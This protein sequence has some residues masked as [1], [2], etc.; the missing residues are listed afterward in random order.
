MKLIS[1]LLAAGTCFLPMMA[2]GT[3]TAQARIWCLSL[4]FQHGTGQAGMYSLDLTTLGSGINGEL[5]PD[6]GGSYTHSTDLVLTDELFGGELPGIMFLNVPDTGDANGNGFSDFFE[7]SQPASATSSGTF[8]ISG[9]GSGT[10]RASWGRAA[11]SHWGS[12]V[13]TLKQSGLV[14]FDV[15]THSFE[16]I[17]YAGPLAYTPGSNTVTGSVNLT[18][19]DNAGYQMQGPAQ[20]VKTPTDRF[21]ELTLRPGNWTNENSQTLAFTDDI[22]LRDSAWPTNYYGYVDFYDPENP[23][24]YYPYGTWILSIDDLNDAN[25]NGIP[26]FS[27]DPQVTPPS[28]PSLTLRSGSTNLWLTISGDVGRVHQVQESLSLPSSRTATN[29]QTVLSVTLTNSPQVVSLPLP[30]STTRFWQVRAQ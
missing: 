26:D 14:T 25:H 22:Y 15:F 24:A 12:C 30:S 16:L 8:N 18:Q 21:N 10:V 29:W 5:A 3:E 19:T 4:R 28:R 13:L 11:G 1:C 17:E 6:W 20:F 23:T 7:V 9:L 2:R 27:D